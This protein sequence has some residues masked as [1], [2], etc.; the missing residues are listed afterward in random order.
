MN[1][2]DLTKLRKEYQRFRNHVL[3]GLGFL[4]VVI[5]FRLIFFETAA[6]FMPIVLILT[7]YILIALIFTLKYHSGLS[8][9][10]TSIKADKSFEKEELKTEVETEKKTKK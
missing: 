6:F 9:E 10:K 1:S 3:A 2:K 7:I 5:V 4:L 8:T